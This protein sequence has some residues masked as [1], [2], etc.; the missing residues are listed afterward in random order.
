MSR[1]VIVLALLLLATEGMSQIR[2]SR[3]Q[4]SANASDLN[5]ASPTE[6][7]IAGI[8]VTGL[9]I[10]DNNAIISL[11]GLRVGDKIKVP[12]DAISGAIRKLW[13]HGLVGDVAIEAE[14]IEG[15]QIFLVIKLAE[16]PRL[17]N[18]YFQG[19]SK[20]RES[21]LKEDLDL[22]KGRIVTDAMVRNTETAVRKHFVKKGFLNTEVKV[23]REN[24]TLSRDGVR[25]R[26]A[27]DMKSKVKINSISFSGNENF[28]DSRLKKKMKKTRERPGVFLHRTLI[29]EI[30]HFNPLEFFGNSYDVTWGDVR[31]FLSRNVRLNVFSS[32]K[33]I[34]SDFAEDKKKLIEFYNSKGYRDAEVVTDTIYRHDEAS[35]DLAISVYEGPKYYFRNIIWTGNYLHTEKTLNAILGI[36]SGD[37]YNKEMID[38]KI[39]FNPKG[40]DISGLYM[41]DGYLFFRI[42]PVE[43]AVAGDSIDVEMRIFEGEQAT[44]NEV[45][46]SGNE[47]TSDHV[48][49]RELRTVPGQKFRRSDII[50]TQQSLSQL[51]YFNPEKVGQNIMPNPANGTVDIEWQVE[52]QSN[53]QIELSGGWGGYYGFVGTLGL[54]FNNF[55]VRNLTHFDKWRPLPVG[56]GQRLSLRIQ[57]NGK[58]YQNYGFSF[59]E[60]WLGG[61]KPQ[62]FS[63]SFNSSVQRINQNYYSTDFTNA[64]KLQVHNFSVGLGRLLEWPDNYFT[65]SNSISY[66]NYD[67]KNYPIFYG[68]SNGTSN[69]IAF[70]ATISR[71]STGDP[72]YPTEGSEIS[73]SVTLTPPFSAWRDFDYDNTDFETDSALQAYNQEKYKW[74]EY[75]KWMFDA[76]YYLPLDSKKKLVLEAKAHFGY[77]GYYTKEYGVGPFER[78]FLGGAGLAGGMGSFVLGQDIIG[79]RGYEDN[80]ITP[81]YYNGNTQ[82]SSQQINGGIVYDKLGLELRYPVTTGNAATIYGFVF[83]EGGNNWYEHKEFN[84]FDMY[85]AAGAGVRL[86]M[87]AFGLIGLN[88]AYGFDRLPNQRDISG[89]QFHF[90]IGQQIR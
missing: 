71:R 67:L 54:T 88:W 84:P 25:L 22:I 32:S 10:L 45:T 33:M 52:E 42:T 28:A 16:R 75:H 38:R 40:P 85:K 20:G 1:F 49:R 70:N 37:I 90:T 79:L 64:S 44:I 82:G 62:S 59:T 68:F 39:T 60:P 31:E 4:S 23:Y 2:R 9:N 63:V 89:S 69:T 7:T 72:R 14:K 87:P 29:S 36:K 41:D 27:V 74:I 6:Y 30:R 66:T 83:A 77:I 73:L 26:I 76:R 61:R 15:D 19:I 34:Q 35:I 86:F 8:N 21:S 12:G 47:R 5:Y 17:M 3:R 58:A 80:M 18:Y 53:D 43:V 56:D 57:A 81:P 48:I 50:R 78:F 24:D 13:N 46:I 55:S 65:L 51:G 11:T